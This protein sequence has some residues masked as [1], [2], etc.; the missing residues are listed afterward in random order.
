M[1]RTS[2]VQTATQGPRLFYNVDKAVGP[3]APNL[4]P[5]VLLVQYFLREIF[6]K[7][8]TVG[9]FPGGE[10]SVDGNPGPQTFSAIVHFQKELRKQGTP[11]A[12][13]G[14]VDPVLDE[15]VAGSISGTHYT[16]LF[17]NLGYKDRRPQDWPHVSRAHDCPGEL[18]PVLRVPEFV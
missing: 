10:V 8:T 15:R 4:R 11:V 5:D 16:I 1:P 9:P 7:T 6:K 13:D 2:L 18:R 3:G 17:L 14:R 12:V